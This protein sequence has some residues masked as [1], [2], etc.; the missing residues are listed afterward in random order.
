L[1]DHLG[2]E[3]ALVGGVSLG[4]ITALQVAALAEHR[5]L[6]LFLE[7]P[8]MEWSTTFAA[9]MF[10]PLIG[11]VDFAKPV[12]RA[13]SQ[14]LGALPRPRSE[15][16]ASVMNL[17]A[18]PPEVITAVL[19]GILVGPV[20]PPARAR[21]A[22]KLPTL[23][24]GHGRDRLHSLADA[25]GLAAEMPDARL[26]TA[27]SVVEL[28]LSPER[29]WPEIAAFLARVRGLATAREARRAS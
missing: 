5:C 14:L 21:R 18:T 7:M 28:R 23:I 8:V 4:A 16:A 22:M 24:L 25:E 27:R 15:W 10:V 6:G 29:L 1:L 11:A 19:H 26:L 12:V 3:R 9:L 13:W 20:V 2:I 17:L